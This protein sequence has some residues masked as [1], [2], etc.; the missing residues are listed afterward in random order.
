MKTK[1]K[2]LLGCLWLCLVQ[3]CVLAQNEIAWNFLYN[4]QDNQIEMTAI[5]APGWHIYSTNLGGIAG[6]IPT[7]FQFTTNKNVKFVG[8]VNEPE[9][10]VEFD[11]NFEETVKYFDKQVVFK[12]TLR[13]KGKPTEVQGSVVYMICNDRMCLPPVEKQFVVKLER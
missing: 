6:P 8:K 13:W 9:P 7:D 3:T 4:P 11:P 1:G 5:L 2:T 10:K 12:Q